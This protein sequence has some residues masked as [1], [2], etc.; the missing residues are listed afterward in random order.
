[1]P[2]HATGPAGSP[3]VEVNITSLIDE[4][5]CVQPPRHPSR[6][7]AVRK[8]AEDTALSSRRW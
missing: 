8:A 3:P 5:Q 1:M 7:R 4:V 6:A 2:S